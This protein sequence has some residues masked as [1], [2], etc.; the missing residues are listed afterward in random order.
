ME[1]Q[2]I[3]FAPNTAYNI[4]LLTDR[5]KIVLPP[6]LPPVST[7]CLVLIPTWQPT[8]YS[9]Y[10]K[11]SEST[12]GTYNGLWLAPMSLGASTRSEQSVQPVGFSAEPKNGVRL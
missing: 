2:T 6:E 5:E 4:K 1:A 8:I 7:R 3:T 11:K 9:P 10:K 12:P